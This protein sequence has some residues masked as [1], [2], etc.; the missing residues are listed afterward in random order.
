MLQRENAFFHTQKN[1]SRESRTFCYIRNSSDDGVVFK[2]TMKSKA[3][4]QMSKR[5]GIFAHN[6]KTATSVHKSHEIRENKRIDVLEHNFGHGSAPPKRKLANP[7]AMGFRAPEDTDI[8]SNTQGGGSSGS[9]SKAGASGLSQAE[10]MAKYG[11]SVQAQAAP[12]NPRKRSDSESDNE[13]SPRMEKSNKEKKEKKKKDKKEK[14]KKEKKSNKLRFKE[15]VFGDGSSSGSDSDRAKKDTL[16]MRSRGGEP[17]REERG[18]GVFGG[19]EAES[20]MRMNQSEDV[21]KEESGG[22]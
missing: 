8:G 15:E 2:G 20:I 7:S 13:S 16:V 1:S 22:P 6:P 14:K 18:D 5:K 4:E 17:R 19:E 21:F 12:S 3:S 10:I 9:T 11:V